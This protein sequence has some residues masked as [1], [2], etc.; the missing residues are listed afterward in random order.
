MGSFFEGLLG[1]SFLRSRGPKKRPKADFRRFWTDFGCP[2][3]PLLEQFWCFLGGLNFHAFLVDFWAGVGGMC[4]GP[5][6]C[7][8][9]RIM[10]KISSRG[11]PLRGCGELS[12]CAHAADPWSL[13][14]ILARIWAFLAP[15][16]GLTDA[17]RPQDSFGPSCRSNG[18]TA[19]KPCFRATGSNSGAPES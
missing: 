17:A 4:G 18:A 3:G 2:W 8:F 7:I 15:G 10:A 1:A 11:Y 5:G 16:G 9:C 19:T 6:A 12:G 14:L 13:T